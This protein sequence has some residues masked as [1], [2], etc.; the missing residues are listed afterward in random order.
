MLPGPWRDLPPRNKISSLRK[1]ECCAELASGAK[2]GECPEGA[3]PTSNSIVSDRKSRRRQIYGTASYLT[4]G[5]SS[6]PRSSSASLSGG[7]ARALHRQDDN[8]D[9][10]RQAPRRVRYQSQ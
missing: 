3:Q 8:G 7:F 4:E 6:G 1:P 10:P 5:G 2:I 9:P